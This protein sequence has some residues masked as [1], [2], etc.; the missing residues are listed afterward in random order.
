MLVSSLSFEA[1]PRV[2]P[3][4]DGGVESHGEAGICE[5]KEREARES[6]SRG[7]VVLTVES[8]RYRVL[9]FMRRSSVRPRMETDTGES[10]T[11]I[12]RQ[13]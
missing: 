1:I 2:N 7:A 8:H 13:P 5:L 6:S 10:C 9:S 4:V 3:E 11:V 12:V